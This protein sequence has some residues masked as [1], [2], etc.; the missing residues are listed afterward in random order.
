[1][2]AGKTGAKSVFEMLGESRERE[3]A[4]TLFYRALAA[5][6]ELH[7][8]SDAAERL[9][10]L[11]AD[12]QHHLSRI[13]ARILELGAEPAE[14]SGP[15][16]SQVALADWEGEARR[17]EDAE[18]TWYQEQLAGDMDPITRG[19]LGEILE[20]EKHHRRELGG[21]WMPA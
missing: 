6:A 1:M 17:R 7:G 21:K 5:E 11:H 8:A 12:E 4:Q 3:K 14:L 19:I 16:P 18:V 20:S 15:K 9:N 2:T 13:T 10:A